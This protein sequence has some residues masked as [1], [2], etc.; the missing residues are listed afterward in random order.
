MSA[1]DQRLLAAHERDDRAALVGLY[2][3]AANSANDEDA[4]GFYLTHA[5]IFAL[6]TGSD[7]APSLHARLIAAGRE[8]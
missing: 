2:L 5:Y 3:E 6:D 8:E 1:L 4:E 7:L